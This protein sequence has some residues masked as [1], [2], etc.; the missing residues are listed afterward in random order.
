MHNSV[1][2]IIMTT[3]AL[4]QVTVVRASSVVITITTKRDINPENPIRDFSVTGII[5]SKYN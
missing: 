5:T 1:Q 4:K 2:S 3:M